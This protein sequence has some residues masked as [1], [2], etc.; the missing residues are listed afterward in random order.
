MPHEDRTRLHCR[1]HPRGAEFEGVLG[2]LAGLV[3]S[4]GRGASARLVADLAG[5]GPADRVV[6]VG[7]GPGRF[8]R[9][10]AARGAEAVGVEPSGQMRRVAGWRTPVALRDRIRV[11]EGTAERLPLEDGTA[12]VVSALAS[13]HHWSDT[14]AGLAE[15]RRVL[16]PGGRLVI[17]E[18]M[19]RPQGRSRWHAMSWEQGQELVAQAERAGFSDVT[20]GRHDLGRRQV[21]AVTARV[22]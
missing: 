13:F 7:S 1:L 17:A 3:M 8:L 5:V 15:A 12:T 21:L 14:G 11:L 4:V 16:R 2:L 10:V 20:A 18:R 6:D 22:T 19:D 9:E